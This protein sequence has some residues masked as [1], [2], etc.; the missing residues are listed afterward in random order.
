MPLAATDMHLHVAGIDIADLK[1]EGLF[2]AKPHGIGGEEE[3]AI[4]EF[5]AAMNDSADLATSQ[6]V[7]D[8]FD[9]GCFDDVEPLPVR[10]QNMFPE[11][12]ETEPIQLDRAPGVPRDHFGKV[13]F[14]LLHA[15][16]VGATIEIGD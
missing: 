6:D 3:D 9:D 13:L 12:H 7:R 5:A 4:P 2:Q 1:R 16:F 11:K 14:Q 8:G 10:L 15:E